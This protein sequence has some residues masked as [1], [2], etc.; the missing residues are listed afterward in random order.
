MERKE[1]YKKSI[2]EMAE[3]LAEIIDN[4]EVAELSRSRS[5]VKLFRVKRRHEVIQKKAPGK[6]GGSCEL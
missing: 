4:G 1:F 6:W 3:Q 2:I 5:G